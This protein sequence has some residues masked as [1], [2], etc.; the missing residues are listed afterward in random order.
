MEQTLEELIAEYEYAD[1][2]IAEM[3]AYREEQR[4]KIIELYSEHTDAD[5]FEGMESLETDDRKVT[6]TWKLTKKYDAKK[7]KAVCDRDGVELDDVA[8]IKYDYSATKFNR[9]PDD[10]R[11]DI[12]KDALTSTRAKT[13]FKIINKEAK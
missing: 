11:A 8:N 12:A 7:L 3:T 2:K 4:N 13:G 9:L 5:D 6:L 10:I 1:E